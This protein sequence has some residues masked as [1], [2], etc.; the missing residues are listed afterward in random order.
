M[1]GATYR[2]HRV[3]L[4]LNDSEKEMLERKR[5]RRGLDV[6]GYFRTLME[7]DADDQP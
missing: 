3:N 2:E 7:E 5:S 6:S 1:A 4:R